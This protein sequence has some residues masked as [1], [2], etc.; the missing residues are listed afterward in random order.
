M[1][2][3]VLSTAAVALAASTVVSAQ[4]FTD[5]N[6]MEKDCKPDPAFGN[7]KVDCDLT[8]GPCQPFY[9]LDGT[10]LEYTD[11]G[12]VFKIEKETNAPTIATHNYMFFGRLEVE[13]NPAPGKGVVTSV[14]LQSDVLDE[15]DWEWVGGDVNQVQTNYFSKG[16]TSTYDRGAYHPVQGAV[17]TP[18]VYTIDWTA[19]KIDWIVNGAVIRTLKASDAKGGKAFPQTPM[20]VKLGTWVAGRKNAPEGT[21]EW[22]GG[23]TD[24]SQAPF[25][26]Y[27]KSVKIVDYAGGSGPASGPVRQ[28]VYGDKSGDWESIVVEKGEGPADGQD[29]KETATTSKTAK[30]TGTLIEPDQKTTS[31]TTSERLYTKPKTTIEPSTPVPTTLVTPDKTTSE[32]AEQT[33]GSGV[34]SST[35][36][37]GSA[38]A[39]SSPAGDA[40]GSL[41][42]AYGTVALAGVV[43]LAQLL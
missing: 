26:A 28:Y 14:V 27:Y 42:V 19:E 34:E 20:E 31:T 41:R 24:F 15:I 13:L 9:E 23:Y 6:P 33:T 35:E 4:T 3:K 37:S 10:K 7:T 30:P 29:D 12:A 16:D 1:F 18:H 25:N 39:T 36:T 40:A 38:A 32:A 2:S 43:A 5:C 8:K 17:G 22:A 11:K 21:V